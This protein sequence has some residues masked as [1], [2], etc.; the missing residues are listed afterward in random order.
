MLKL[1]SDVALLQEFS[2]IPP[3]VHERFQIRQERPI[4]KGD[5]Q[6]KFLNAILVRGSLIRELPLHA[7]KSWAQAEVA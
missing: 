7:S 6:Q 5:G 1:N 4:T 2:G 3:A